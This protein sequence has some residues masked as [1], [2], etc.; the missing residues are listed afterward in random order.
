MHIPSH[1]KSLIS[2]F[3][4]QNGK[5]YLVGGCV[6]DSLLGVTP[7]D[8][9]IAVTT[10]PDETI[11]I[12]ENAGYR[13]I[14]SGIKHGTVTVL[15]PMGQNSDDSDIY[16]HVECTT[17]R[18][19]GNY[20]DGRHPDTI[21]FSGKIE[22]DLARRDF[23]INAMAC[24]CDDGELK[25]IDLHGGQED[26]DKKIIRTVGDPNERFAEDGLRIL[27][28]IRFAVKLG[29]FIDKET[30]VAIECN[31]FRLKS[32]S[33]ERIRDEFKKILTSDNPKRGLFLLNEFDLLKYILPGSISPYGM[34][35]I[36]Q[37]K[38]DFSVRMATL[39]FGM[40]SD[41]L[42]ENLK[43]LK[44][45]NEEI[46]NITVLATSSVISAEP[47]SR[48]ARRWRH[49]LGDLVFDG[50]KVRLAHAYHDFDNLLE[51]R[52]LIEIS[53]NNNDP[54]DIS[55]LAINGHDLLA[56]GL[57]PDRKFVEIFNY[58]LE[59]IWDFPAKNKKEILMD[60]VKKYLNSHP[61]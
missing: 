26:L 24:C 37:V 23:T 55:D 15:V 47:T 5:A 20:S 53:Q 54:V 7:H 28:S 34:G 60:E 43:W 31:A 6:R 2:L 29:F 1:I 27:R 45:S 18:T 48:N 22:D 51:L 59:V 61:N 36:D 52:E 21:S 56:L 17:C 3:S 35:A 9:D 38:E 46:K 57:K 41:S 16:D 42:I 58:L 13:V 33:H 50:I 12:C 39:L 10:E 32:I 49:I 8:W 30:R 14:P 11:S 44:L 4:S 40:D 25:I 19:E